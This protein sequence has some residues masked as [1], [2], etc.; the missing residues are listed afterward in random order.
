MKKF[1]ALAVAVCLMA[2]AA[3]SMASTLEGTY[4]FKARVKEGKPDLQNWTGTMT[5]KEKEITRVYKSVDGKEEKFYT[6]SVKQDGSVY[7]LKNVKA[8]KPEYVGNEFRNKITQNGQ[9]LI[10]ESEDGKFKE[11]WAKR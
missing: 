5:V 7:V 10:I 9:D 3:V 2:S 11:T 8:Y 4:S 1:A 6:S